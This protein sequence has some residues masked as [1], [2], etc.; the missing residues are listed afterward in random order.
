MWE[1]DHKEGWVPKNWC[2]W[3]VVLEKTLESS[4]DSKRIK[5]VNPKGNQFSSVQLL[6]HVQLFATPWRGSTPGFPVRRQLLKLAETHV[7]P[8]GDVIQPSHLL[9]FPSPP[10][11]SLSQHHGLFQWVSY[12]QSGGQSIGVSASTSVLPMNIWDW[13]PLVLTG[14]ISSQSLTATNWK[15]QDWL[16][17]RQN[18]SFARE[19]TVKHPLG[20]FSSLGLK[21]AKAHFLV[22]CLHTK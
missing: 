21:N 15:P 20:A 5:P 3:T 6:S 9:S 12:S 4:L 17:I 2:F 18:F 22:I 7:H 13:F 16:L 8:V 14:Y 10:T 11:F 19:L 1:L